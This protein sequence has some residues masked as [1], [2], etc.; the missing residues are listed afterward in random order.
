MMTT[1]DATTLVL[2]RLAAAERTLALRSASAASAKGARATALWWE[3]P[4]DCVAMLTRHEGAAELVTAALAQTEATWWNSLLPDLTGCST[5]TLRKARAA[6]LDALRTIARGE[7]ATVPPVPLPDLGPS[8]AVPPVVTEAP[9]E[10]L[11]PAPPGPPPRASRDLRPERS[12]ARLSAYL[13]RIA[14]PAPT[15]APDPEDAPEVPT[16][17]VWWE[18]S[19]RGDGALGLHLVSAPTDGFAPFVKSL[20]L[21][22]PGWRHVSRRDNLARLGARIEAPPGVAPLVWTTGDPDDDA[23]YV[24]LLASLTPPALPTERATV[25]RCEVS[26]ATQRLDGSVLSA[27][28]S[29]AVLLPPG[30]SPGVAEGLRALDGGWSLWTVALPAVPTEAQLAQLAAVGLSLGAVGLDAAWVLTPPRRWDITP[31]GE[32]VAVFDA[33][34]TPVVQVSSPVPRHDLLLQVWGDGV[35]TPH[36]LATTDRVEVCLPP[37]RPGRYVLEVTADD[38]AVAPVRL[39]WDVEEGAKGRWRVEAPTVRLGDTVLAP[40]TPCA[41]D[42][43]VLGEALPWSITAPPAM[44]LRVQWQGATTWDSG[45]LAADEDGSVALDGAIAETS[46]HRHAAPLGELLVDL[47]EWGVVRVA[48]VRTAVAAVASAR[49]ALRRAVEGAAVLH[50][51]TTLDPELVRMLWAQPVAEALGYTCRPLYT[52]A[53]PA[54]ALET[55]AHEGTWRVTTQA[56]LALVR[57][58]VSLRVRD[59]DDVRATLDALGRAAGVTRAVVSDGRRWWDL[60]LTRSSAPLPDTPD[61]ALDDDDGLEGFLARYGAWR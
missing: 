41:Y 60:D 33:T 51:Q 57:P 54:A 40:H 1:L 44:S 15:A 53:L 9:E 37:G 17:R 11:A 58:G 26:G 36:R 46:P 28:R 47:G 18:V 38:C 50:A 27:G 16:T 55:V 45:W 21:S 8:E 43:S 4:R 31:R 59:A 52:A 3:A 7:P 25:F 48:H 19:A 6:W 42:L 2:T 10:P 56:V 14:D 5:A 20:T 32:R 61:A 35:L 13:R 23:A 12:A 49:L 30:L 22:G 34:D 29:Y 24:A 39:V